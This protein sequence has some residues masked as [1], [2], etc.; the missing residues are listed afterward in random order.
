M[1]GGRRMYGLSPT[2][3][4][5]FEKLRHSCLQ[6]D[7]LALQASSFRHS[8]LSLRVLLLVG[9]VRH[10]LA[11]RVLQSAFQNPFPMIPRTNRCVTP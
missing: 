2:S 8:C 10:S 4:V 7:F 1:G 9:S 6:F 11:A 3:V 5:R